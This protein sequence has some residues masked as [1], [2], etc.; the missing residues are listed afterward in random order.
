LVNFGS[1]TVG[2]ILGAEV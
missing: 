2:N 1:G